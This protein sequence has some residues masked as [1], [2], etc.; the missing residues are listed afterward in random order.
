MKL[1]TS[2]FNKIHAH[3]RGQGRKSKR[4][5]YD[6]PSNLRLVLHEQWPASVRL[7]LEVIA[8]QVQSLT[9]VIKKLEREICELG[10]R[11]ELR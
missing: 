10:K 1:R 11:L 6:H 8:A 2:L 9:E 3:L 4:E 7:E 5:S